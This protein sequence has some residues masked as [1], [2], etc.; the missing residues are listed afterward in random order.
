M[1][2]EGKSVVNPNSELGGKQMSLTMKC[3]I[4]EKSISKKEAQY[5]DECG[6]TTCYDCAGVF[7]YCLQCEEK[8]GLVDEDQTSA[9]KVKMDE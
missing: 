9:P 4:C 8:Y 6:K 3:D 7:G 5:C 1:W 2:G